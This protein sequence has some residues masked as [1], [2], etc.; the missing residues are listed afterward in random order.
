MPK[1]RI[2]AVGLLTRGDLSK[3]GPDFDRAWPVDET[4]CFGELLQRIDDADREIRRHRDA[5]GN[6]PIASLA[7]GDGGN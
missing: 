7:G 5:L 4:P 1:K 2:V 6:E 3:L